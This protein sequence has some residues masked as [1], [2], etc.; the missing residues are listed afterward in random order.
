[1][2]YVVTR[3]GAMSS[4]PVRVLDPSAIAVDSTRSVS[5]IAGNAS[6]AL[7]GD[8]SD[9]GVGAPKQ[10]RSKVVPPTSSARDGMRTVLAIYHRFASQVMSAP[11]ANTRGL[12]A[13]HERTSRD[14]VPSLRCQ[15][16]ASRP[17]VS[18]SRLNP[19]A[20][21]APGRGG[22]A[23]ANCGSSAVAEPQ[24]TGIRYFI[25]S[26][27]HPGDDGGLLRA[28][29]DADGRFGRSAASTLCLPERL[30][31][32][33]ENMTRVPLRLLGLLLLAL[34]ITVSSCQALF[35]LDLPAAAP[36]EITSG[37]RPADTR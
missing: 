26:P 13:V 22:S 2:L 7:A 32:F 31:A 3:I 18:S 16:I 19:P 8:Q 12:F 9:A 24:P 33:L 25:C 4:A 23:D 21:M 6:E 34:G 17:P 29:P 1:M 15:P 35:P 28:Q 30:D 5:D 27:P 37:S 36:W 10:P 20:G 11:V 14:L